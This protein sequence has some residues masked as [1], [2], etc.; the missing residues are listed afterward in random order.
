MLFAHDHRTAGKT[1]LKSLEQREDERKDR[2]IKSQTESFIN[3]IITE[4]TAKMSQEVAIGYELLEQSHNKTS[5]IYFEQDESDRQTISTR[6]ENNSCLL[7]GESYISTSHSG[8]T[9]NVAESGEKMIQ[10]LHT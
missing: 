6:E 5:V 3:Y 8:Y 7:Q 1:I 9:T 4:W 2:A 10:V